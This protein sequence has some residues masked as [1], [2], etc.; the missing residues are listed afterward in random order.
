M[1]KIRMN[2]KHAKRMNY[3]S[4]NHVSS[5]SNAVERL[6]NRAKLEMTSQKR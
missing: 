2:G 5:T 1:D 4:M 6:F 3:K